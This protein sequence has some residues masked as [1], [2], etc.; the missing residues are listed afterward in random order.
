MKSLLKLFFFQTYI[1]L[2]KITLHIIHNQFKGITVKNIDNSNNGNE[3]IINDITK[4]KILI[5]KVR[6]C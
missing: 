6:L 1:L 2:T 4:I 3:I 5:E